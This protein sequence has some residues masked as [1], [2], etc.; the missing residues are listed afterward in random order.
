MAS[1]CSAAC[2][3][4]SQRRTLSDGDSPDNWY[5]ADLCV[6]MKFTLLGR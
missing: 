4:A 1:R 6:G 2:G 3:T 5:E